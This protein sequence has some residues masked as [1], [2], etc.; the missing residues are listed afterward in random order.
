MANAGC[1]T[2]LPLFLRHPSHPSPHLVSFPPGFCCQ[3][4][5]MGSTSCAGT[6]P[7]RAMLSWWSS[8]RTSSVSLYTSSS[9]TASVGSGAIL[10]CYPYLPGWVAGVGVVVVWRGE[11][12]H[13]AQLGFQQHCPPH[14]AC[15]PCLLALQ[16]DA[17][18]SATISLSSACRLMLRASIRRRWRSCSEAAHSSSDPGTSAPLAIPH[19]LAHALTRPSRILLTRLLY[20]VPVHNNPS[21]ATLSPRR[22]HHLVRL[23]HEYSFTVVAD[24]VYQMLT[25]PGRPE[26]PPPLRL[27][28]AQYL[29]QQQQRRLSATQTGSSG[30]RVVSLGSFSKILAP[31]LRLG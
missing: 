29:Q 7:S 21:A 17:S 13:P 22:R 12:N 20:T 25:F 19:R 8:R 15:P 11:K 23:A 1:E 14:F 24:E 6:C 26:P 18:L 27:F 10:E 2:T 9:R 5:A 31:G 4:S 16:P 3:A 28:E 30:S